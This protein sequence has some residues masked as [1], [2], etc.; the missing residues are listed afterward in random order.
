MPKQA[1]LQLY[2]GKNKLHLMKWRWYLLLLV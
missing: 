1:I 2:R